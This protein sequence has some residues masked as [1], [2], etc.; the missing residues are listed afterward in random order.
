MVDITEV[1]EWVIIT[2]LVTGAGIFV[3]FVGF[4]I[5]LIYLVFTGD[6][7]KIDGH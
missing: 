2:M 6:E 3:L 1:T 4:I 5:G 7:E